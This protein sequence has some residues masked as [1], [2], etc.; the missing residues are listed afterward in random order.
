MSEVKF[1]EATHTYW[2]DGKR[3]PS[4]NTIIDAALEGEQQ[5]KKGYSFYPEAATRGTYVHEAIQLWIADELDESSL[6]PELVPYFAAFR[7]CW[8]E[9]KLVAH[10]VERRGYSAVG[11]FCGTR[12]FIG[13]AGAEPDSKRILLDWKTG[14]IRKRV[15]YQLG[16]YSML[17]LEEGM[18]PFHE[19]W[20]VQLKKDSTYRI[21]AYDP[22][23][24]FKLWF[25]LL[26]KYQAQVREGAEGA[27]LDQPDQPALSEGDGCALQ[28]ENRAS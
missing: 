12:D 10:Y 11:G 24:S 26:G 8:K 27:G 3:I 21:K 22:N 4:V 20:A 25:G 7:K 9:Q 6:D 13:C 15:Q 23:E 5:A 2:V 1:D 14:S 18:A 17:S 16:G 28:P 19:L